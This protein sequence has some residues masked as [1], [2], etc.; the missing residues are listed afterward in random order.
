MSGFFAEEQHLGL[1]EAGDETRNGFLVLFD[2]KNSTARKR[3]HRHSWIDQTT[4][5]YS[6]FT[7]LCRSIFEEC[8]LDRDPV[9]KFKGDGLMAFFETS[10]SSTCENDQLA[11]QH[12]TL[13]LLRQTHLFRESVHHDMSAKL[14]GMQLKAVICYL[15]GIS[16]VGDDANKTADVLG[17]GIDFAHRLEA[18]ADASHIVVNDMF[19]RALRQ[20]DASPIHAHGDTSPLHAIACDKVIK[21]WPDE[22]RLWVLTNPALIEAAANCLSPSLYEANAL[23]ELFRFYVQQKMDA[24]NH[25]ARHA[26]RPSER[27]MEIA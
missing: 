4:L 3:Q 12:A 8:K 15:N 9:I 25:P 18:F 20:D 2:I 11:P 14:G 10:T 1:E 21:G 19:Y 7:R 13:A 16:R 24:R 17:R 22:Q 27:I 5:L 26:E 23:S 6:A